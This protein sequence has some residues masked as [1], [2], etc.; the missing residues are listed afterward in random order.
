MKETE[1][2]IKSPNIPSAQKL[3]A[4]VKRARR[5]V[6]HTGPWINGSSPT[7][8]AG[9]QK[10]GRHRE[11]DRAKDG[12]SPCARI[13]GKDFTHARSF[14]GRATRAIRKKKRDSI[15]AVP[16]RFHLTLYA[17]TYWSSLS[18]SCGVWFA[19]INTETPAWRRIENL[20]SSVV[21]CAMSASLM[22]DFAFIKFSW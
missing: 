7:K 22:R 10:R 11:P 6:A 2:K 19:C 12:V 15:Q 14:G 5:K 18:A 13:L 21:S 16:F 1:E 8:H 3:R 17:V 9:V 4:R 20:V